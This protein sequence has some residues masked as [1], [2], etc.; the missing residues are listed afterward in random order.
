MEPGDKIKYVSVA[1]TSKNLLLINLLKS[2]GVDWSN[3]NFCNHVIL[4]KQGHMF[5]YYKPR[6]SS[7]VIL[8][9]YPQLHSDIPPSRIEAVRALPFYLYVLTKDGEIYIMITPAIA[10]YT[11]G[12]EKMLTIKFSKPTLRDGSKI[13]RYTRI[14]TGTIAAKMKMLIAEGTSTNGKSVLLS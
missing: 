3:E 12:I 14:E 9:K 10:K 2:R 1:L 5:N 4:T 8:T 6:H 13:E 11:Y 7:G